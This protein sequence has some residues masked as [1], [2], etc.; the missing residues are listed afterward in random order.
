MRWTVRGRQVRGRLAL[1]SPRGWRAVCSLGALGL[2]VLAAYGPAVPAMAFDGGSG[3]PSYVDYVTASPSKPL[4]G[5]PVT[6]TVK[7]YDNKVS[8]GGVSGSSP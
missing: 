5:Q 3:G 7:I 1:W 6:L 4:G 2:G 8:P